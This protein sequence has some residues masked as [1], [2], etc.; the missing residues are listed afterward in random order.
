MISHA[1]II[2]L[3]L[4]GDRGSNHSEL[5]WPTRRRIIKGIASG[6]QYLHNELSAYELPHGNLKSS[7]ILLNDNY[8][9]LLCDYGYYRMFTPDQAAQGMFACKAPEVVKRQQI[10][11]KCDVH[12]LGVVILELL[13]GKFPSQYRSGSGKGGTDV[14]QWVRSSI[15]EDKEAQI[16][17]PEIASSADSLDSMIR[18][19]HIGAACCENDPDERPRLEEAL[20]SIEELEGWQSGKGHGAL[21]QI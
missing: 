2:C 8:E 3:S 5:N 20:K 19:L 16:L 10:S 6:I 18:L 21:R 13:T 14:I 15:E 7:N 12:C 11:P 1:L 17:D 9:P 4:T